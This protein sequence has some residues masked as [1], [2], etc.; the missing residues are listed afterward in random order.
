M[1]NQALVHYR[2]VA[3]DL[4]SI[5]G[6]YIGS[7]SRSGPYPELFLLLVISSPTSLEPSSSI[8]FVPSLSSSPPST[9]MTLR[10]SV[11]AVNLTKLPDLSGVPVSAIEPRYDRD[12]ALHISCG[13][14][15]SSGSRDDD[16]MSRDVIEI[17]RLRDRFSTER[18]CWMS[19]RASGRG[20]LKN[21]RIPSRYRLT[22]VM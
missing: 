8:L 12:R 6:N 19:G 5:K 13:S 10:L 7:S 18:W 11:E 3:R 9:S 22:L 15:D 17:D 4:C 2:I 14:R 20:A 21:D 16:V 1:Q